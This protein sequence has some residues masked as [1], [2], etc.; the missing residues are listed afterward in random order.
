VFKIGALVLGALAVIIAIDYIL[1]EFS[2]LSGGSVSSFGDIVLL[3][4]TL[5]VTLSGMVLIASF[6]RSIR[7][8]FPQRLFKKP[9]SKPTYG[10]ASVLAIGLGA[11]LGSPLFILIPLNVVQYEFVSLGSLILA[12][13][14]SILM[15]KVYANMYTE[16]IVRG[17]DAMGGPSFTKVASGARSVR[18]FIARLSM[19]IANTA[20]AAYS[21]IVFIVFDFELMPGILANFGITGFAQTA[22]V[23][24]IT[25]IFVSWTVLNALFEQRFLKMIGYIQIILTAVMVVILVWQ[26]Y[27]LGNVGSWNMRGILSAGGDWPFA[28]VINTGYLY[29]LFFGFQEIQ[30][31][32]RDVAERSAIPVISWIK[33]GY[34]MA[35]SSYL[36]V[37]M[38]LSV[39]IA[40]AIN[41]LYAVAVYALH[42]S[43]Q[44]LLA[45]QIPA[46]FLAHVDL[47]A[48]EE[49]L[50]AVAFLTATITTFVPAFL[51]ASRH[52]SAL[53]EDG[54][55][56]RSVSNLSYVFTLAAILILAVGNENFLI[57]I[58]DFLVLISLGI[59]CLSS[60]WLRKHTFFTLARND[61]LPLIVGASC[62]VAGAAVYFI[63]SSVA[64]FGSVSIAIVY[65]IYDIYELGWLG[66]QLF[67]GIFD[68]I[69]FLAL[70]LFP[71]GGFGAQSFFLFQWLGISGSVTGSHLLSIVLMVCTFAIFVNL[72]VDL[73]LRSYTQEKV[74]RKLSISA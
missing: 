7:V 68:G 36:G 12:T 35:K 13:V 69:V 56:P 45:S 24:A 60:V 50:T 61:L 39:L 43:Y 73:S 22:I 59:I 32:E 10:F 37:A 30:A 40:A 54:F 11:T 70:I 25:G 20:L 4:G 8:R 51:A 71:R 62:F 66:T 64:I 17:L 38:I 55:I 46:L 31:L 67:L 14:L 49:I 5:S 16:S 18:Y 33:R 2:I 21:K 58:T 41:I 63:S 48:G 72:S 53:A 19:W 44:A 1:D 74:G 27:L 3:V 15:A 34:S 9:E 23:W 52:L 42:P 29:L 47:G 28:L 57:D 26:S 6:P 65:L